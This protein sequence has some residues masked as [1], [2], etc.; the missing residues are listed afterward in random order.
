MF[1]IVDAP[2]QYP[3]FLP[4]CTSAVLRERSAGVTMAD[5]II[6]FKGL[7]FRFTTRNPKSRPDFML[8]HLVDGPFSHFDGEWRFRQLAAEACEIDFSLRYEFRSSIVSTVSGGVFARIADKLV[9][10]FVARAQQLRDGARSD[11]VPGDDGS[12]ATASGQ[13]A[14]ASRPRHRGDPDRRQ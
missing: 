9:D 12:P 14:S 1:D 2:E 8:I 10:A 3:G 7:N 4:W 13:S 11:Q 5:I 6:D